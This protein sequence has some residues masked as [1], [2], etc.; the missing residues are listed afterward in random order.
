MDGVPSAA[1][2]FMSTRTVSAPAAAAWTADITLAPTP[3][4]FAKVATT[5]GA[6]FGT[7]TIYN[8]SLG[9]APPASDFAA[10][11]GPFNT[12]A[13]NHWVDNVSSYRLLYA[14]ITAT[15][16]ASATTNQGTVVCAQYS[17]R[18]Q[19]ISTTVM[20][21]GE[22]AKCVS[23]PTVQQW[24]INRPSASTLQQTAGAVQWEANKGIYSILKLDGGFTK[25]RNTRKV[26]SQLGYTTLAEPAAAS[27]LHTNCVDFPAAAAASADD[28]PFAPQGVWAHPTTSGTGATTSATLGATYTTYSPSSDNRVQI[29]FSG[30]APEAS[31]AITVRVGYEVIVPP[32]S[33]YIGQVGSP[34][35][36]DP[37][38][39]A[40]YF[41]ISREMLAGYPAEYNALGALFS[42]IKNVATSA[43]PVI[44]R[45]IG[46]IFGMGGSNNNATNTVV[47]PPAK[48]HAQPVE[49]IVY[50]ERPRSPEPVRRP[51]LVSMRGR[52]ITRRT[53]KKLGRR[54]PLRIQRRER[55]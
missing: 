21:L 1:L 45:A 36:Y 43:L 7:T 35:N 39:L 20:I 5:D 38:A 4:Y 53:K 30:L 29:K 49:R 22:A 14:S 51:K 23:V 54:R 50:R 47:N 31:I 17:Q 34:V 24:D 33:I 8:T 15:L 52:T 37:V 9:I 55:Y 26:P 10:A 2:N 28:T 48:Q 18:P 12:S 11:S 40:A 32:S 25:W 13:I 27:N 6:A 44:G 19:P 3:L 42:V 41:K 16:S 46:S